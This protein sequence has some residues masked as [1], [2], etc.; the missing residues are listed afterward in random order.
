MCTVPIDAV[1][2]C[3]AIAES[4]AFNVADELARV[5]DVVMVEVALPTHSALADHD[6]IDL[7]C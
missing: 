3:L 1:A 7:H 6:A 5:L 2:L 4:I